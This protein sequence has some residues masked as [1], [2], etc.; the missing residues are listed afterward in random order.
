[1]QHVAAAN[2]RTLTA[3]R[4]PGHT[5]LKDGNDTTGVN[6]TDVCLD[7]TMWGDHLQTLAQQQANFQPAPAT[8]PVCHWIPM[9]A[10]APIWMRRA[11]AIAILLN[12]VIRVAT[13]TLD[14]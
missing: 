5:L 3:Y 10:V 6:C 9:I 1:M 2:V 12:E 8:L 13:A 4:A 14:S 11:C 7:M